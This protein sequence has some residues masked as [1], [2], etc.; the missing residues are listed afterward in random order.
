MERESL[1]K[2]IYYY[3]GRKKEEFWAG[4]VFYFIFYMLCT[5]CTY[6]IAFYVYVLHSISAFES[7]LPGME[8]KYARNQM[9]AKNEKQE[10]RRNVLEQEEV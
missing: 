9:Y 10:M 6:S 7:N 3:K 4:R 1:L 5:F 2:I 8:R